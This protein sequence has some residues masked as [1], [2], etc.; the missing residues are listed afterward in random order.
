MRHILIQQQQRRALTQEPFKADQRCRTSVCF[1][2]C[3]LSAGCSSLTLLMWWLCRL[4][5]VFQ[6]VGRRFIITVL[7]FSSCVSRF[8]YFGLLHYSVILLR[9]FFPLLFSAGQKSRLLKLSFIRQE[10]FLFN[11]APFSYGSLQVAGTCTEIL[12]RAFKRTFPI[13]YLYLYFF[14][15]SCFLNQAS[16]FLC[17]NPVEPIPI[18]DILAS[19]LMHRC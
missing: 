15:L 18:V 6:S 16:S 4:L 10:M 3:G 14:Q 12:F 5:Y 2:C 8:S 11:H 7:T 17:K 1:L 19:L 13:F 9:N